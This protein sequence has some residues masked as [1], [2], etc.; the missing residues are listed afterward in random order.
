[1]KWA[2]TLKFDMIELKRFGSYEVG[3]FFDWDH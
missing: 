2:G 1:M 3:H